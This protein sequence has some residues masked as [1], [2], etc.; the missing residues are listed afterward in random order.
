MASCQLLSIAAV[1]L[2]T[3]T[4]FRGHQR[5]FHSFAVHAQRGQTT[6]TRRNRWDR[7]HKK[8]EAG[9]QA[10]ACHQFSNRFQPVGDGS[11]RAD[12]SVRLHDRNRNRLCVYIQTDK[13]YLTHA[14]FV[15]GSAPP[16]SPSSQRN[17]PYCDSGVCRSIVTNPVET[18]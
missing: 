13:A 3:I 11:D 1:C 2:D 17:P 4:G 16:G 8:L 18:M 9:G 10:A 7:P 15:C 6:S 12:F 14:T 5:G